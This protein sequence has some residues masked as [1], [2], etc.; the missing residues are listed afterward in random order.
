MSTSTSAAPSRYFLRM[1]PVTVN[2]NSVHEFTSNDE[3]ER[4]MRQ[5][6]AS[7][8]ELWIKMHKKGSGLPTINYAEALDVML[9]WGWIDGI[10][11]SLNVTSFLQRYT[12]RRAKSIWSLINT[13]HVAR[14]ISEKRMQAP[15]LAQI[16]SAKA[17]GRWENAYGGA[18]ILTP[19]DD[20]M[21]AINAHRKARETYETLTSQNRYALSF[22]LVNI[23]TDAAR[24]RRIAEYVAML[25]RGETLH[26][27][28]ATALT[29]PVAKTPLTTKAAAKKPAAVKDAAGPKSVAKNAPVRKDSP[30]K[31][32]AKQA[33]KKVAEKLA[34]RSTKPSIAKPA[35][36]TVTK[37][38]TK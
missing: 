24:A 23:K 1:P 22:R 7:A 17:D 28:G 36:S 19:P 9:C 27:N 29:K 25:A 13:E 11:K 26:P 5:N 31:P 2:P 38:P 3:L 35:K 8:P 10:R 14:L 20:L 16:D 33:I 12:P 18:K 34:K 32:K 30:A 37:S 21:A 6:H 15:G 4:W